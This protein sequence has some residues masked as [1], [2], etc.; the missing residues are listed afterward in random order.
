M[1]CERVVDQVRAERAINEVAEYE[2][3]VREAS[4]R[5]RGAALCLVRRK[6]SDDEGR[7][8]TR[9]LVFRRNAPSVPFGGPVGLLPEVRASY[10]NA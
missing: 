4:R 8:E 5:I 2:R 3:Y 6:P 9:T 1:R 7:D 10:S